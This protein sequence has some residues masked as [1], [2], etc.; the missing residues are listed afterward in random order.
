[1][2]PWAWAWST[3]LREEHC[4][5]LYYDPKSPD[6]RLCGGWEEKYILKHL[7]KTLADNS[8][9]INVRE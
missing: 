7:I 9:T 6:S 3:Y 8:I 1:M 5:R 4:T 2:E